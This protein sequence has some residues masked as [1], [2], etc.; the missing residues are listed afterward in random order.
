[1]VT[2]FLA[3]DDPVPMALVL[4]PVMG[5]VFIVLAGVLL[6]D[7]ISGRGPR[8]MQGKLARSAPF[9]LLRVSRAAC[10]VSLAAIGVAALMSE[11][12]VAEVLAWI[13]ALLLALGASL[14]TR[15]RRGGPRD[16]ERA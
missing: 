11:N 16:S 12:E 14:T 4:T 7:E 15:Y 5:G 1:M 9:L 8:R 2:A 13:S 6:F 10:Y 3:A